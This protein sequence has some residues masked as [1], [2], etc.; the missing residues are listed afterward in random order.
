VFFGGVAGSQPSGREIG[1]C[2]LSGARGKK[3]G[4]E[5]QRQVQP[6]GDV[7]PTGL[8]QPTI[9]TQPADAIQAIA[10]CNFNIPAR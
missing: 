4:R 6:T 7:Q 8:A 1:L 5:Q 9:V 2:G 10:A 3:K